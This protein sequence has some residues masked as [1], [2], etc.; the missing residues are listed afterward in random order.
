MVTTII[1]TL[2]RDTLWTRTLP[3]VMAQT[4]DWR[5][6]IVGDGVDLP[7]VDDPRVT[8]LT[9]P[10]QAYPDDARERWMIGGTAAFN[11]GLDLATT[12]WVSY[13]AD[14]DAYHPGHHG[15][16]LRHARYV[17]VAYGLSRAGEQFYGHWPPDPLG[18]VQGSYIMRRSTGLRARET[19]GSRSWDALWWEDALAA[20]LRFAFAD[21]LVHY[22]HPQADSLKYHGTVL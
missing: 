8:V 13:L 15:R 12:E 9:I 14:D 3:S 22:Y 4:A 20:G 2:G 5:C 11:A 1:P 16:L 18:I 17:D 6:I 19:V 7:P 21:E 10:R